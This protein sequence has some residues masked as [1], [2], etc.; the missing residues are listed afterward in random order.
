[1]EDEK[2]NYPLRKPGR[3][4]VYPFMEIQDFDEENTEH[5]DDDERI[6]W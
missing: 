3:L 5:T 4:L 1:M 6:E 2:A